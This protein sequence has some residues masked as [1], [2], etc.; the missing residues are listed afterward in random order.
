MLAGDEALGRHVTRERD[1]WREVTGHVEHAYRFVVQTDLRLAPSPKEKHPE[2]LAE[3]TGTK[4]SG[5][6]DAGDEVADER[7]AG[8]HGQKGKKAKKSKKG[9]KSKKAG[10][11][12]AARST[13]SR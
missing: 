3:R 8:K 5:T 7:P 11:R 2:I 12:A 4:T 10:R 6:A 13:R 1:E 9:K